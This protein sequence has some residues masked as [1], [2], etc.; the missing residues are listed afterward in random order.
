MK[1]FRLCCQDDTF[2]DDK[3]PNDGY[4]SLKHWEAHLRVAHESKMHAYLLES[5]RMRKMADLKEQQREKELAELLEKIKAKLDGGRVCTGK[6]EKIEKLDDT[7]L[8]S[9]EAN[10]DLLI[11]SKKEKLLTNCMLALEAGTDAARKK[12]RAELRSFLSPASS[13]NGEQADALNDKCMEGLS[14]EQ[15]IEIVR[16]K[17]KKLYKKN[18]EEFT[19]KEQEAVVYRDRDAIQNVLALEA[20]A[21]FKKILSAALTERLGS[22]AAVISKT[23]GTFT[24]STYEV[25]K[26]TAELLG[27]SADFQQI[28][29]AIKYRELSSTVNLFPESLERFSDAGSDVGVEAGKRSSQSNQPTLFKELEVKRMAN[30]FDLSQPDLGLSI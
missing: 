18:L 6:R 25:A 21:N 1:L 11:E 26:K 30:D 13:I 2:P 17:F 24:I 14:D 28:E 3:M 15:L 27:Y 10:N 22:G 5:Q 12:K 16:E 8:S 29:Q 4:Q 20:F 19:Y 9:Q 23:E 7:L